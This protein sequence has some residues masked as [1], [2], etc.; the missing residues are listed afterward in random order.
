MRLSRPLAGGLVCLGFLASSTFAAETPPSPLRLL[1]EH[2]DLVVQVHQP[3]RLVESMVKLDLL[4]QLQTISIVREQLDSTNARKGRQLLAYFERE[5]GG[6]WPELLE[7]LAGG[8]MAMAATYEKDPNPFLLVVQ[9]NDEK[10]TEKFVKAALGVVEQELARQESK[11]KPVKG[12][13]ENIET[14]RVGDRFHLARVGAAILIADTDK[15]LHAGLDRHLGKEKKSLADSTELADA[16]KLLPKDAFGT[17]WLNME[18]VRKAPGASTVYTTPRDG[19][20]AVQ[21]GSYLDVLGRTPYVCAAIAPEKDGVVLTIRTPKGRDGMGAERVMHIPAG[22]AVGSRPLLTPQSVLFSYSFYLDLNKLY[23]DRA[24]IFNAQQAKA[25]ETADANSGGFLS[26][27]KLS[28]LFAQMGTYHRIVVANQG[29][30]GYTKKSKVPIP[31]FAFISE[32]REPEEFAKAVDAALR[33][34]AGLA[35]TQASVKSTEITHNGVKI[36]GYRFAEDKPLRNDVNDIRYAFSPCYT[37]VGNQ[38]VIA[39]TIEFCEELIDLLQK[40]QKAKPTGSPATSRMRFFAPGIADTLQAQE[41]G[42]VTQAVLDQALTAE[43]ARTQVRSALAVLRSLGSLSLEA[44]F[45][46]NTFQ[47]DLRVKMSK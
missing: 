31:N 19:F 21:F 43:E 33:G 25:L 46:T 5:L 47:F 11:E 13:Y 20:L 22:D 29:K 41:D 32:L 15:A 26:G 10:L 44:D 34:A 42:L 27:P 37:R 3:R 36:V 9:G 12:T 8:G 1:P 35:A 7:K 18:T 38:Y 39:S 6:K 23:E 17:V 16:A 40:E 14:V 28:K 2:P 4:K 24:K 30:T 45:K